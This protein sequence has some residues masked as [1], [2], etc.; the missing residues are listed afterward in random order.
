VR[1][2]AC[3]DGSLWV[4]DQ[5]S[6]KPALNGGR[7]WEELCRRTRKKAGS[8]EG[9]AHDRL[10]LV[11]TDIYISTLGGGDENKFHWPFRRGEDKCCLDRLF[12]CGN[13]SHVPDRDL[14][15]G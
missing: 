11:V 13:K 7:S 5:S 15:E 10:D 3:G 1:R 9:K 6:L 4:W 2:R 12:V 8:L 14:D